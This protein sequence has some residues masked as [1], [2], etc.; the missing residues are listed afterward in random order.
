MHVHPRRAPGLGC[1]G[2]T[3]VVRKRFWGTYVAISAHAYQIQESDRVQSKKERGRLCRGRLHVNDSPPTNPN[4]PTALTAKI[5]RNDSE[6]RRRFSV[7]DSV[8]G[9]GILGVVNVVSAK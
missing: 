5:N 6:N 4:L 2:P 7:E 3:E 1:S 9:L 8:L